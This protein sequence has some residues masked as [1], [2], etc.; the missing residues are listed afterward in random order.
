MPILFS[1]LDLGNAL[2][3]HR[4]VEISLNGDFLSLSPTLHHIFV[5]HSQHS[6]KHLNG[7]SHPNLST[8]VSW[9]M[10]RIKAPHRWE[11]CVC[12]FR[13][14]Q[15]CHFLLQS[16]VV[17]GTVD[18]KLQENLHYLYQYCRLNLQWVKAPFFS[19]WA[20]ATTTNSCDS[21][22]QQTWWFKSPVSTFNLLGLILLA[23]I[24]S[25]H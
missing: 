23:L 14:L 16:K 11:L 20:S 22:S 15:W 12:T 7:A 19:S 18:G 8:C 2:T 4:P 13:W 17:R 24:H 10:K 21:N 25:S 1:Y 6:S 5:S 9:L 3:K